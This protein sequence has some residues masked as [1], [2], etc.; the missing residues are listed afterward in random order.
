MYTS[1]AL[2]NKIKA[3]IQKEIQA[4]VAHDLNH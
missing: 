2:K 3:R 4:K 1:E